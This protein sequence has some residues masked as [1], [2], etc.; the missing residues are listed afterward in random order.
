MSSQLK[1]EKVEKKVEGST[2]GKQEERKLGQVAANEEKNYEAV[3][4]SDI[5]SP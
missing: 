4:K 5:K 1:S 3:K 2:L